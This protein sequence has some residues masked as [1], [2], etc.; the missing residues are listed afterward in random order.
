MSLEA[1][2]REVVVNWDDSE[3]TCTVFVSSRP[4]MT[5]L[6][7]LVEKFPDTYKCIHKEKNGDSKIYEIADKNLI[8]FRS[9][10]EKREMTDEQRKV[11]A[12]RLQKNRNKG[13]E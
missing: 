13:K 5:V 8:T 12:D 3:E 9:P 1:K 11:I 4:T 6:D 2:E 7:K 10:R